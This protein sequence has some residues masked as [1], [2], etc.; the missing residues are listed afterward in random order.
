ME[1]ALLFKIIMTV[2]LTLGAAAVVGVP[3]N[4]KVKMNTQQ[5]VAVLA[6]VFVGGGV[7]INLLRGVA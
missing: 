6:I 4:K 5:I 3:V 1:T 7:L 2:L